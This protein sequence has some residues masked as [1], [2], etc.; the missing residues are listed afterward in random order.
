MLVWSDFGRQPEQNG[1]AGTAQGA[2]GIGLLIG[3]RVRGQML[4]E[5]PGLTSS[6]LRV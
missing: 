1:S 2:A 3:S 6:G 5:F 4:G